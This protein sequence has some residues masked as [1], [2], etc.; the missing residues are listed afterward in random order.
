MR[1][2]GSKDPR[3]L[4]QTA[5]WP[6]S[7]LSLPVSPLITL[8]PH[9][10]SGTTHSV[11]PMNCL[12]FFLLAGN[13]V[14]KQHTLLKVLVEEVMKTCQLKYRRNLQE[15]LNHSIQYELL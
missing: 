10:L 3:V 12:P 13:W 6:Q 11:C 9:P 4:G 1:I 14:E 8:P 2:G 5:S 7:P 15:L